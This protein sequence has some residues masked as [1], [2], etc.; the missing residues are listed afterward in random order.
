VREQHLN[1]IQLVV[2]DGLVEQLTTLPK[3]IQTSTSTQEPSLGLLSPVQITARSDQHADERLGNP[4]RAS[5]G[6][7]GVEHLED[8]L[9]FV[10]L[11]L[12]SKSSPK[13][14]R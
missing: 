2:V 3:A 1:H 10:S 12:G 9:G 11:F 14:S 6:N 5:V 4:W 7:M 8:M 13:I